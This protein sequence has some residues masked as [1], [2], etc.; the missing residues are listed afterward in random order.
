MR[1]VNLVN[2]NIYLGALCHFT[3]EKAK[4]QLQ[5]NERKK[6]QKTKLL[7]TVVTKL[8]LLVILFQPMK[9]MLT[10]LWIS[11]NM[12]VFILIKHSDLSDIQ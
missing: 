4:Y 3:W 6:Y 12:P 1:R 7:A 8:Q 10:C 9:G 5:R 2:C 11:H